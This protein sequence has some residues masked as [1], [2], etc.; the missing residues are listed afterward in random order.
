MLPINEP[1]HQRVFRTHHHLTGSARN[2]LR[3]QQ[4]IAHPLRQRRTHPVV[5]RR[6][7]RA[8]LMLPLKGRLTNRVNQAQPVQR[9]RVR[10]RIGGSHNRP[11]RMAHQKNLLPRGNPLN[12]SV[13]P[14]HI[15]LNTHLPAQ[16]IRAAKPRQIRANNIRPR[17]ERQQ[18]VRNNLKPV[19]I[20]TEP[21]HH[22]NLR[23]ILRIKNTRIHTQ[24]VLPVAGADPRQNSL[25]AGAGNQRARHTFKHSRGSSHRKTFRP[26][27]NRNTL[28]PTGCSCVCAE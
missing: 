20:P 1:A 27:E 22:Q 15:A 24:P 8:S 3:P 4:R 14:L 19:M 11:E 23:K 2:Q 16:L 21:V 25:M 17:H 13:K 12:Q 28:H 9:L 5:E 10:S 6:Q 18:P 7:R 26:K